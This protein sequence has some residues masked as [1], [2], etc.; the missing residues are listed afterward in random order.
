M[1]T[2]V[3][4]SNKSTEKRSWPLNDPF[5]KNTD[6]RFWQARYIDGLASLS[7]SDTSDTLRSCDGRPRHASLI[8]AI[9]EQK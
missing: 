4:L 9:S 2:S 3:S 5:V 1:V 7:P 6:A 8:M